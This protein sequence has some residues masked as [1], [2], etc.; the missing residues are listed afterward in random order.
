MQKTGAGLHSS[1]VAHWDAK[2]D[3]N[4]LDLGLIF[5]GIVQMF[6]KMIPFNV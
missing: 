2:T 4:D 5:Q 6:G 1:F 3:G